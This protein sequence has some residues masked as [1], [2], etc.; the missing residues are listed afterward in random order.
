MGIQRNRIKI[1]NAKEQTFKLVMVCERW[2][3][4]S[5]ELCIFLNVLSV[6]MCLCMCIVIMQNF[7]WLC[8]V[9]Q[10]VIIVRVFALSL[11]HS[12]PKL[13]CNEII[14]NL[15]NQQKSFY[16]HLPSISKLVVEMQEIYGMCIVL[17]VVCCVQCY[18]QSS[19]K[20]Q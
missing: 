14:L 12:L 16:T 6:P 5:V 13:V 9:F 20:Y 10:S 8:F 2:C 3:H 4:L 7:N 11:S 1:E 19:N 18:T 17:S 15:W